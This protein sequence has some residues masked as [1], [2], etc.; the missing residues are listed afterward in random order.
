MFPREK[1]KEIRRIEIR[2]KRAVSNLFAGHYRSVFKGQGMEFQEVREYQP[3]DDIRTIDW[4]VTART[5]TPFVKIFREERELTML[6]LVDISASTLYSSSPEIERYNV[7]A[8]QRDSS[9]Q[10]HSQS[11][12]KRHLAAE[13]AAILAFS[14]LTNHDRVGLLL[15]S[16]RVEHFIPPAK[17]TPHVLR[18][19]S[20]ILDRPASSPRTDLAPALEYLNRVLHRRA[21]VFLLS[22]FLIPSCRRLLQVTARRHDLVSIGISDPA[23]F[24]LPAA[25]FVRLQDPESGESLLVDSSYPPTRRAFAARQSAVRAALLDDLRSARSDFLD[26]STAIPYE[27]ELIRFFRQREHRK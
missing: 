2:S 24:A 19:V 14:A 23:D 21:L 7:V 5:G 11:S 27:R 9:L 22:D 26:L 15:F 18:L 16:D 8:R 13:I 1:L 17:G 4:N 3:G 20:E 12:L 6:L 25:G 10:I